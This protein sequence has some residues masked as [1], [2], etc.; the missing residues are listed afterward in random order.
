MPINVRLASVGIHVEAQVHCRARERSR[1]QMRVGM[2]PLARAQR[3]A[4]WARSNGHRDDRH[5][6]Q[7]KFPSG[8]VVRIRERGPPEEGQRYLGRIEVQVDPVMKPIATEAG[9]K[10]TTLDGKATIHGG[11]GIGTNGLL[12]DEVLRELAGG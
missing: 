1:G 2:C 4:I 5:R 10:F 9:G 11:S 8:V 6:G 12:H 7:G 3:I